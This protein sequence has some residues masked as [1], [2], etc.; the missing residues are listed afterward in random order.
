M[1]KKPTHSLMIALG[2]LMLA[3][4]A[5]NFLTSRNQ[6]APPLA[7]SS[8]SCPGAP[9]PSTLQSHGD[10]PQSLNF[11]DRL[12]AVQGEVLE[13]STLMQKQ[14]Y[15]AAI[16]CWDDILARVP[17]YADG[18]YQRSLSY[19]YLNSNQ[20]FQTEYLD[21]LEHAL[22]DL[23][24]AISLAPEMGDYY[25]GRYEVEEAFAE[26]EMYLVDKHFWYTQAYQDITLANRYGTKG[27]LADRDPAFLLIDLG[28]C[29]EAMDEFNRLIKINTGE[30]S[31]G[32]TTGLAYSSQC[33]GKYDQAL[34]Y[35]EEAIR[36][37]PSFQRSMAR[38]NILYNLGRLDEALGE[39]NR[40]IADQ[41]YYCG[42]RYYLRALI[43]YDQGKKDLAQAD[44]DFGTG[45]TWGRGGIRSYVLGHLAL[46]AGDRGQGIALLQEA[47]A[48]LTWQYGSLR[49]RVQKELE[50]LG[51][52]PLSLTVSVSATP[53]L[54]AVTPQAQPPTPT[55]IPLDRPANVQA[56][57]IVY[58][59][60][61]PATFLPRQTMTFEFV[62]P[63]PLRS[64][65]VQ[66]LVFTLQG[67]AQVQNRGV[68]LEIWRPGYNDS[69]TFP[70]DRLGRL[71]IP[72]GADYV[73]RTGEIFVSIT[74]KADQPTLVDVIGVTLTVRNA[75]GGTSQ[76]G[77]P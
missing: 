9:D 76:Y 60:N 41:R 23:N 68:E 38:A 8:T 42:C 25:F 2:T 50:T 51:S 13:A 32:L 29:Q 28:R 46:D 3:S 27:Q 55:M 33:L 5:C 34:K 20:R 67:N 16:L 69:K 17:E 37:Y 75:N 49:K 10:A 64:P 54:L 70:F 58:S 73:T 48:S 56:I 57:P 45:Q 52:R 7:S 24:Q 65:V 14:Q 71:P 47:E 40:L 21:Y 19:R 77:L 66:A 12:S 62:S 72:N 43:Y 6:T 4:L 31:A 63:Q 11:N 1:F 30:P 74:I 15:A 26:N 36:L 61:P 39:V 35:I 59:G 44:I 53:T 18:Y 22:A